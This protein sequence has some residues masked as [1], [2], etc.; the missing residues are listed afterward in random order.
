MCLDK[1]RSDMI[2]K[3]T[4]NDLEELNACKHNVVPSAVYSPYKS[5][6]AHM[7]HAG[8]TQED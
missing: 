2:N 5:V 7:L 8:F 6:S 4:I 3:A 1:D